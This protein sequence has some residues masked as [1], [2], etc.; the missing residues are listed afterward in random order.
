MTTRQQAERFLNT[1]KVKD[2]AILPMNTALV[3][4]R[5]AKNE[6]RLGEHCDSW[7]MHGDA[8]AVAARAIPA[9]TLYHSTLLGVVTIPEN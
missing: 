6:W 7:L 9:P 8:K 3:V 1:L 4:K 5:T 2:S